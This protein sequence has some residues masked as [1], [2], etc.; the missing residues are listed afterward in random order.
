MAPFN[1]LAQSILPEGKSLL[2]NGQM[3]IMPSSRHTLKKSLLVELDEESKIGSRC[4][5]I[6]YVLPPNRLCLFQLSRIFPTGMK[7]TY[8]LFHPTSKL[9]TLN[10]LSIYSIII[11]DVASRLNYRSSTVGCYSWESLRVSETVNSTVV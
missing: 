10:P 4:P 9:T 8:R 2:L 1:L 7:V 11:K 5:E 6:I 3:Q